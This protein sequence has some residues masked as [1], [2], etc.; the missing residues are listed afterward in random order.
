MY[1]VRVSMEK[2]RTAFGSL[3]LSSMAIGEEVKF[4]GKT[5]TALRWTTPLRMRQ[6]YFSKERGGSSLSVLLSYLTKL[7]ETGKG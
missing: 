1:V 6:P 2:D 3:L 7:K 5:Y 4:W